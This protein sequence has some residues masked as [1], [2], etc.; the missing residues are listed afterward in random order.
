MPFKTLQFVSPDILV[1]LN[2][3]LPERSFFEQLSH[4]P[5]AAADGAAKKLREINILPNYIV[6][7][8]DSLVDELEEWYKQ[9]NICIYQES[10]QN[11]TD[12]E[13]T[14]AFI[15]EKGA[16]NILVCGI[17]GGDLDHTLN[18]WSITIRESKTVNLAIF[19]TEKTACVIQDS[20]Q[21]DSIQNE[22]ISLIPQMKV[23]LSTSGLEW[24]LFNETLEMGIREGARNRATGT[25]IELQI[26][27]GAVLLFQKARLPFMPIVV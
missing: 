9:D 22:M 24:N 2:G 10:D 21:F 8:L 12:Y 16:K 25:K 17:H 4:I 26:H 11:S 19:D 6:G 7:D 27:S 18:N 5:K 14:L 23:C 13:K 3:V 20:V 15:T 1:C